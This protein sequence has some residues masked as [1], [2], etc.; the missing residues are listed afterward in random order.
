MLFGGVVLGLVEWLN[1]P[2]SHLRR[3]AR[4][5]HEACRGLGAQFSRCEEGLSIPN[6]G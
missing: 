3:E 1:A 6:F 4:R 2:L 5:E